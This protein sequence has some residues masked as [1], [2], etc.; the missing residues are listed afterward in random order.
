MSKKKKPEPM[1][2]ISLLLGTNDPVALRAML[3]PELVARL[4]KNM[5]PPGWPSAGV[6]VMVYQYHLGMGDDCPCCGRPRE[7]P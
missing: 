7:K 4:A 2:D 6:G 5:P 1:P 3:G